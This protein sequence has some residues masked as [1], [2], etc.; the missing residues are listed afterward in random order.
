MKESSE[1]NRPLR[2]ALVGCGTI[3]KTQI[4]SLREI[5]DAAEM[6]GLCDTDRSKAEAMASEFGLRTAEAA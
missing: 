6:I 2:F 4:R 3:A 1:G 5:G